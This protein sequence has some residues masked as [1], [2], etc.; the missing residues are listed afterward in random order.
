MRH[1]ALLIFTA[2]SLTACQKGLTKQQAKLQ[3]QLPADASFTRDGTLLAQGKVVHVADGDTLTVLASNQQQYKIRLQGIDAPE[4]SQPF[5]KA[6]KTQLTDLTAGQDASVEAYK[7]DKYGRVVAKVTVNGQDVALE[8]L[9]AG[10]AW[11]YTAYVKEQNPTDRSAYA[12]AEQQARG[13][14]I[15][16]WQDA[17]PVA[18][19]DYRHK[20]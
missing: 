8:Q 15:G 4:R 13:Q 2:L 18:P 5:G 12:S 14:G 6:C 1:I 16:L 19:W 10:C 17:N 11:H 7:Q 9:R 3:A 20:K